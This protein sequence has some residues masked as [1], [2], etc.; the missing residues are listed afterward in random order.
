[1]ILTPNTDTLTS[2]PTSDLHPSTDLDPACL[3]AGRG[4]V[5]AALPRV[6]LLIQVL[7]LILI[8]RDIYR[9]LASRSIFFSEYL[10]TLHL[11]SPHLDLVSWTKSI[12]ALLGLHQSHLN[13]LH[14]QHCFTSPL[15]LPPGLLADLAPHLRTF[16]RIDNG[17]IPSS[18][19]Y[20]PPTP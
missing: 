2:E 3:D 9:S 4:V 15:L 19:R 10:R 16:T 7:I 6:P 18:L 5:F 12:A 11:A 13:L 20:P 8:S 17:R 14:H 1:V